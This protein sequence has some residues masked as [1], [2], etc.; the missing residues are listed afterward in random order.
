MDGPK[1]SN[2]DYDQLP[3]GVKLAYTLQEFLWLSDAEKARLLQTETEPEGD[4]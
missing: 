1:T 2:K 4:T 3:E